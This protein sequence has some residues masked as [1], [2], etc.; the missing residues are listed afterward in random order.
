M[1]E[2][3]V[4]GDLTRDADDMLRSA[5]GRMAQVEDMQRRMAEIVGSAVSEDERISV[6]FSE[7]N[8]LQ[9]LD[10]DPRAMRLASDDLSAEIIRLVNVAREDAQA[11][12]QQLVAEMIG[13]GAP[14]PEQLLGQLPAFEESMAEIL[15]DTEQMGIDITDIVERMQ[16]Q[17]DTQ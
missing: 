11:Q 8:G 2:E 9:K 17:I 10:L 3:Y 5:Q 16:R 1:S 15:R 12:T 7:A 14:D 4:F 6:A 13:G